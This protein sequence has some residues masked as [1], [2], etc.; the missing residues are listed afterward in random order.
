MGARRNPLL[1]RVGRFPRTRDLIRGKKLTHSAVQMKRS[2]DQISWQ[3]L[4]RHGI[5]FPGLT[6]PLEQ[7]QLSAERRRKSH[8]LT[9]H[10]SLVLAYERLAISGRIL[11][12]SS[13]F[14]NLCLKSP[15][16]MR[17]E[18]QVGSEESEFSHLRGCLKPAHAGHGDVEDHRPDFNSW[19]CCDCLLLVCGLPTNLLLRPGFCEK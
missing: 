17:G 2:G 9:V 8:P 15:R 14:P 19:T 5:K 3:R 6:R 11:E 1:T 10:R 7:A 4:E 13:R 12:L 18:N 16:L